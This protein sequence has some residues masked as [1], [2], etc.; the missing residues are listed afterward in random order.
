MGIYFF[1]GG[2]GG[3]FYAHSPFGFQW[4]KVMGSVPYRGGGTDEAI[5]QMSCPTVLWAQ[6]MPIKVE[7]RELI[8][9]SVLS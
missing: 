4:A 7:L 8:V 9:L 6:S 5:W 3:G 2:G 1:S